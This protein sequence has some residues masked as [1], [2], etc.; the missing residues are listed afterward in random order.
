MNEQSKL[1]ESANSNEH[2]A[3]EQKERLQHL[4][5]IN[6]DLERSLQDSNQEL[7]D[8]RNASRRFREEEAQQRDVV[9][10]WQAKLHDKEQEI[11]L[12]VAKYEKSLKSMQAELEERDKDLGASK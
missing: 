12:I 6:Y 4:E 5:R 8:L 1:V 2:L 10:E 11:N 3:R 9:M 7:T